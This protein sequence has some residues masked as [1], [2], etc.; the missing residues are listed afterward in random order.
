MNVNE[1]KNSSKLLKLQKF[2]I[3]N[4]RELGFTEEFAGINGRESPILGVKKGLFFRKKFILAKI[5]EIFFPRKFLS[6]RYFSA[7]VRNFRVRNFGNQYIQI[8]LNIGH[9]RYALY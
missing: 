1:L 4:F 8:K 6:L 9:F 7:N 3:F 5:R 2:S